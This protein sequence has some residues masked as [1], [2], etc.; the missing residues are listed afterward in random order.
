MLIYL[1]GP[2]SY[3]RLKKQKEISAQFKDKN[4]SANVANFDLFL[5]EEEEK[6][7]SFL[8]SSG[9]FSTKKLALISNLEKASTQTIKLLKSLSEDKNTT[10]IAISE[11]KLPAKFAFLS[12]KPNASQEFKNLEGA[13]LQKFLEEEAKERK[14]ALNSEEAGELI[15]LYGSDLWE[16][17]NEIEKRVL[18]S[19]EIEKKTAKLD[20]FPAVNAL[21]GQMPLGEKLGIL[22]QILKNEEPAAVFNLIAALSS[23]DKKPTM[24]NYDIAIKSGK[25]DYPEVLLSIVLK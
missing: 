19:K 23:P 11:K 22:N 6:F 12:K 25:L 8:Q 17:S 14:Y 21:R 16:I 24:A 18:G 13:S 10:V 5:K 15:A 4:Q 7:E 20:F 2:D 3:R 9:L 1:H